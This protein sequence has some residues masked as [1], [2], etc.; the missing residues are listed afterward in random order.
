MFPPPIKIDCHDITEILLKINVR[1]N[2]RGYQEWTIHRNWQ[3]RVH[4]TKE[5]DKQNKNTTQYVVDTTLETDINNENKSWALLQTTG[6]KDEPNIVF[7]WKS[8]RTSQHGTKNVKTHNRTTHQMLLKTLYKTKPSTWFIYIDNVIVSV[9][10]ISI[11]K[12]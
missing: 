4:K 5:E 3:H 11:H 7:M 8:W 6:G 12:S 2:R 10:I 9:I 1:E